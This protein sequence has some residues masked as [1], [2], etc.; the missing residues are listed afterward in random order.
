[1]SIVSSFEI[2]EE[3]RT[4]RDQ[5]NEQAARTARIDQALRHG[6]RLRPLWLDH[7]ANWWAETTAPLRIG[8]I[9]NARPS[10]APRGCH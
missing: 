8:D 9:H 6:G 7:F 3:M 10:A 4:R 1:M 5:L 2:E